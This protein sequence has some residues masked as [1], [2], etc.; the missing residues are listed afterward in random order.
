MASDSLFNEQ[1]QEELRIIRSFIEEFSDFPAGRLVKSESP[2]FI[3]KINTRN[4]LGIEITRLKPPVSL[5]RKYRSREIE[6][7]KEI[8]EQTIAGK[9]EKLP[10]YRKQNM[11]RIWL[12]IT[13]EGIQSRTDFNLRNKLQNWSFE[14]GFNRVFL[15]DTVKPEIFEIA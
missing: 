2:D 12:I 4:S 14:T 15:F 3:L 1:S 13:C 6:L 11:N 8:L 7:N 5:H 10:I 9:E